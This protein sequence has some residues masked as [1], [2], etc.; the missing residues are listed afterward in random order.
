LNNPDPSLKTSFNRWRWY[1]FSGNDHQ[2]TIYYFNKALEGN[3]DYASAYRDLR[4]VYYDLGQTDDEEYKYHQ[5]CNQHC[6]DR[7]LAPCL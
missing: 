4:K 5:G 6:R 1:F 2:R 7:Y 3:P